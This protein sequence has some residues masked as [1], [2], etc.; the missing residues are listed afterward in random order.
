MFDY[1]I[2]LLGICSE[3]QLGMREMLRTLGG[4]HTSN[5][6]RIRELETAGALEFAYTLNGRGRPKKI[7]TISPLGVTILDKLRSVN[8]M[9]IKMNKNDVRSVKEQLRLRKKIVESG[10]DPYEKFLEMNEV[11]IN[12]R[13]S[14]QAIT[15]IR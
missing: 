3:R 15:S 7:V 9:M 5:M 6:E 14:A 11:A 4:S 12:I 8:V 2:H 13:D 10:I 1:E